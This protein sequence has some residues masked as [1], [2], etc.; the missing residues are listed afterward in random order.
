V[1]DI[2]REKEIWG[3]DGLIERMHKLRDQIK[4][5]DCAKLKEEQKQ[6]E[7]NLSIIV[8]E[9]GDFRCL[10]WPNNDWLYAY[11]L[12]KSSGTLEN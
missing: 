7:Q 5:S 10:P 9:Q 1:E 3:E 2:K 8:G 6:L 4:Q 11:D 12:W